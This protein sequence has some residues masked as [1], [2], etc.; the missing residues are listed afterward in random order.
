ML[1]RFL[2]FVLVLFRW[3]STVFHNNLHITHPFFTQQHITKPSYFQAIDFLAK[4]LSHFI[5]SRRPFLTAPLSY[6]EYPHQVNGL[7][8]HIEPSSIPILEKM[9]QGG[10]LLTA[11]YSNYEC[12]GLWLKRLQIPLIASYL[13]QKP[14]WIHRLLIQLRTVNDQPYAQVLSPRQI[15]KTLEQGNLYS[16]LLDQDYRFKNP[17][18]SQFLQQPVHCN[19]IPAFILKQYPE[20]PVYFAYLEYQQKNYQLCAISLPSTTVPILYDSYHKQLEKC[21]QNVPSQWYGFFHRRFHS[22]INQ[23]THST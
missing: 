22:T 1:A 4:H 17:I 14:A 23:H 10:L 11:H 8:L 19:P 13:P 6:S 12:M 15:L 7:S 20:I 18:D 9:K 16:L 2:Q 5:F 3:K 21:I